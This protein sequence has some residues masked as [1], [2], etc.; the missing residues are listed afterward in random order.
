[1][2][3]NVGLYSSGLIFDETEQ[4]VPGETVA[5]PVV[6][7]WYADAR[8]LYRRVPV[9]LSRGVSPLDVMF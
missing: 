4:V 1:M 5:L 6:H 7:R 3:W 2:Y 8:L 9:A